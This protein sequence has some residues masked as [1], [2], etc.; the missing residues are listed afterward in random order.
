MIRIA[1][2][3]TSTTPA[4]HATFVKMLPAIARYARIAFRHLRPEAR[5]EAICNACCAYAR[6]VEL[7]KTDL[8]YP[9]VLARYAVAQVRDGRKV[10]GRL[11]VRDVLSPYCQRCK[12]VF[13][14]RLD[15]FDEEDNAWAEVVVEDRHVGPAEVAATRMDFAAWLRVLPGRL[16]KIARVLATGETTTAAAKRFHVSAGRVS[17]IRMELKQAWERFQGEQPSPAAA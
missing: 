9:T 2:Q 14:E 3:P 11:N 8:A 12:N 16:R 1:S 17:Q 7:N 4:W 6:L 10:G 13:V 5:E 15:R